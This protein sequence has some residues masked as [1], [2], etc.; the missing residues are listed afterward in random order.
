MWCRHCKQDVPAVAPAADGKIHCARCQGPLERPAFAK[1]VS[2]TGVALDQ[3]SNQVVDSRRLLEGLEGIDAKH[4]YSE[5]R[6][7]IRAAQRKAD[8]TPTMMRFDPP[9][10]LAERSQEDRNQA[11]Q[12]ATPQ[13]DS[14]RSSQWVAWSLAL[15]GAMALGAGLGLMFWSL[16][17][18][19]PELWN[20]GVAAT[21][22]GQ[23]LLIVGLVQLLASLWT[24]NRTAAL[25]LQGVQHE[26][27]RLGQTTESLLGVR[28]SGAANFYADL[29]RGASPQLLLANLKSQV[30]ALASHVM[31]R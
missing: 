8:A 19:R 12:A 18:E 9:E 2:D 10:P 7:T 1:E 23:G 20:W 22:G 14:H 16:S 30:D 28:T 24:A 26:L 5:I 4:R 25:T 31:R 15:V 27:R 21:L 6:R 17:G 11:A 3:Q 29:A 13:R